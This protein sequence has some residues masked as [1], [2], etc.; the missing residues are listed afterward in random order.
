VDL[1]TPGGAP[2][3]ENQ[4]GHKVPHETC[5]FAN[6]VF[7]SIVAMPVKPN[8]AGIWR[9]AAD[10]ASNT[11]LKSTRRGKTQLLTLFARHGTAAISRGSGQQF[12][13]RAC[14]FAAV[15]GRRA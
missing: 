15:G 2:S 4:R 9:R 6:S 13:G 5:P 8:A 3:Y 14:F 1:S 10:A 12:A 11:R 7:I